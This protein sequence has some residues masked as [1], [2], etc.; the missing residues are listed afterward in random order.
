MQAAASVLAGT[1][2]IATP[3]GLTG[4]RAQAAEARRDYYRS[5]LSPEID[6]RGEALVALVGDVAKR[7]QLGIGALHRL[8]RRRLAELSDGEK[9]T[10]AEGELR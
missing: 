7:P 2:G 5:R 6:K 1:D 8:A 10:T 4:A 3:A 9:P